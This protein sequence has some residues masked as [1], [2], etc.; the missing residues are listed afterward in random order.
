MKDEFKWCALI[1]VALASVI[2]VM[3]MIS[4]KITD[5]FSLDASRLQFRPW[6]VVT[7]IF[8]H[9]SYSHLYSNMIALAIFGSILEKTV[10]YKNFL[11][12]FFLTGIV[13]GLASLL[14][15]PS[16]IGASGAVF[17][18]MGALAILRPKMV[19]WAM[20]I[21]MPMMAVIIIY[22][23]LNILGAFYPSDIAYAGHISALAAGIVIGILWMKRYRVVEKR[24][25]KKKIDENYFRE[26][27]ERYMRRRSA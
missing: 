20:G 14:F 2:F 4:P 6:T 12:V 10:G 27:E 17:G 5:M 13:S 18:L 11:K 21:P 25:A 19:V 7:Y 15:Y 3:Q 23:A 9:G 1:I 24:H 8:L 16:V 26:W 22:G